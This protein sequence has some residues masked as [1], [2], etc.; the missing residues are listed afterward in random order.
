MRIFFHLKTFDSSP[1]YSYNLLQSHNTATAPTTEVPIWPM[2]PP[3]VIF[4]NPSNHGPTTLPTT[5][6][7]RSIRHPLPS[8]EVILL[9]MYPA[10][11][12]IKIYP[13]SINIKVKGYLLSVMMQI[14]SSHVARH[15]FY[16]ILILRSMVSQKYR[17]QSIFEREKCLLPYRR[18]QLTLP[19]CDTMPP[20]LGEFQLVCLVSVFVFLYLAFPEIRIGLG[21]SEILATFVPMPETAIYENACAVLPHDEVGMSWQSMVI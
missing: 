12:P 3:H 5:P 2:V 18:P 7:K 1:P 6:K 8:P 4:S 19:Y 17:I 13:I 14:F 16:R 15:L 11:I 9:A 21:H 10:R 20:Q